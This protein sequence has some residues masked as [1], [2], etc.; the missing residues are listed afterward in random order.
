MFCVSLVVC[1][2]WCTVLSVCGRRY[3]YS[4]L[5]CVSSSC[6]KLSTCKSCFSI[7]C[8]VG[9]VVISLCVCFCL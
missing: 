9:Y 3:L 4:L 6:L 2:T 1:K 8:A 7:L 5:S